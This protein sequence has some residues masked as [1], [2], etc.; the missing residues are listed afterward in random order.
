M[1]TNKNDIKKN[2]NQKDGGELKCEVS[3]KDK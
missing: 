2:Y 1:K 3:G